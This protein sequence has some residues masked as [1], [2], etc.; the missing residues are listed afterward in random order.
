MIIFEIL[1]KLYTA[2]DCRWMAELEDNEIQPFLINRWL[3]M[4]DNIRVQTRWLNNYT[5]EL[6]VKMWLSLAWSVLPKFEKAP[7]VK[8]IKSEDKTEEFEFLLKNVRKQFQMSDNDYDCIK[9]NLLKEIKKDMKP[10]F[11]YYGIEKRWWKIHM[12]DFDYIKTVNVAEKKK[13]KGLGDWS[14]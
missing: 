12:I 10:W 3:S 6:P 8:Y 7:F 4:N 13:V 11:A 14:S 9:D 1:S 2:K 5:F